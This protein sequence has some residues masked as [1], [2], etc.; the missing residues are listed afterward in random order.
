MHGVLASFDV[1]VF[2][3][4]D[5]AKDIRA[6][7]PPELEWVTSRGIRIVTPVAQVHRIP[8]VGPL[9]RRT[10]QEFG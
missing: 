6:Y 9:V 3:R 8:L 2:T 4:Y 1:H 7:L 5:S 10:E